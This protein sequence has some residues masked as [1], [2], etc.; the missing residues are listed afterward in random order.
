MSVTTSDSHPPQVMKE[1]DDIPTTTTHETAAAPPVLYHQVA[2]LQWNRVIERCNSHPREAHYQDQGSGITAL[3]VACRT[4]DTPPPVVHA[5]LKAYPQA[6]ALQT[7]Q[8]ASTPL[9]FA[10]WRNLCEE[11]IRML[12]RVYP[13]AAST[14]NGLG[15]TPLHLAARS[16]RGNN[17]GVIA[18]LLQTCPQAACSAKVVG[19]TP[20]HLAIRAGAAVMHSAGQQQQP[21]V[22]AAAASSLL[23]LNNAESQQQP[24]VL[25]PPRNNST[26]SSYHHPAS[27]IV[28]RRLIEGNISVLHVKDRDGET[29]LRH[30]CHHM[31]PIVHQ[32]MLNARST[33][34]SGEDELH[35]LRRNPI[36]RQCWETFQ[37]LVKAAAPGQSSEHDNDDEEM[38]HATVQNLDCLENFTFSLLTLK[39]CQNQLGKVDRK[40]YL[41]V[42]ILSSI[43]SVPQRYSSKVKV[44]ASS[45][46][47]E[48]ESN[49]LVS[50]PRNAMY[51]FLSPY[52][53]AASTPNRSG[54]LPLHLVLRHNAQWD[55]GIDTLLRVYPAAVTIPDSQS[56]L[57]PFVMAA[58]SSASMTTLFRLI[59]ACPEFSRFRKRDE[60]HKTKSQALPNRSTKRKSEESPFLLESSEQSFLATKR[61]RF[62]SHSS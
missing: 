50:S 8:Y 48:D 36:L 41:P 61:H 1:D 32:I 18:V 51:L 62:S 19:Y 59:R 27:V 10:C 26:P 22:A 57:Y 12:L 60:Q 47:D 4:P 46:Q 30:F 11:V 6:A 34:T 54:D 42:H 23:V 44:A 39:L 58:E 56:G 29:P 9:H 15:L 2:L 43:S 16:A 33:T 14:L 40:G 25:L 17:V 35:Y 3:H 52:P 38:V 37:L 31:E 5:L 55:D 13:R 53:Q 20:L 7:K 49:D 28:V 45:S 24:T 21:P